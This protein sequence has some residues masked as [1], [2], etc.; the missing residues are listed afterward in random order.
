MT[1]PT[2]RICG[3]CKHWEKADPYW[4]DSTCR[5]CVQGKTT[6]AAPVRWSDSPACPAFEPTTDSRPAASSKGGS[7]DG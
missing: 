3:G 7:D 4:L 1:K 2:S 5:Y 6:R